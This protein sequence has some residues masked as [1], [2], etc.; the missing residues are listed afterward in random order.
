MSNNGDKDQCAQN[1]SSFGKRSKA[2]GR[3]R[4]M[5]RDKS[6]TLTHTHRFDRGRK[7]HKRVQT[8]FSV[9]RFSKW[10]RRRK[11][12]ADPGSPLR[13]ASLFTLERRRTW[14]ARACV[15]DTKKACVREREREGGAARV[16]RSSPGMRSVEFPAHPLRPAP[17]PPDRRQDSR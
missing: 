9:E 12:E 6:R 17:S 10:F 14:S 2:P 5:R 11:K 7:R 4:A 13:S 16:R 3:V 1:K 8:Y 15:R